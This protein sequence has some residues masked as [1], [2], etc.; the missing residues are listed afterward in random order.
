MNWLAAPPLV[1]PPGVVTW[2]L[3]APA[4]PAGAVT[5]IDVAETTEKVVAAVA[6]NVTAVAPLR[7]LPVMVTAVPPASGPAF[8]AIEL[9]AGAPK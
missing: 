2:I 9:M 6:P 1:A 7:L 3:T 4:L 8:G 5:V